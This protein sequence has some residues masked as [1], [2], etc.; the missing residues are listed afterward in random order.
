[1]PIWDA[2]T[3]GSSFIRYST[4][5]APY[6]CFLIIKICLQSLVWLFPLYLHIKYF[7]LSESWSSSLNSDYFLLFHLFWSFTVSLLCLKLYVLSYP[8]NYWIQLGS[9]FSVFC[10]CFTSRFA[11]SLILVLDWYWDYF[12]YSELATAAICHEVKNS[13]KVLMEDRVA[14]P[15]LPTNKKL[16]IT[17]PEIL[18]FSLISDS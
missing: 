7:S 17:I 11:F 15:K 2:S 9:V 1:M 13:L 6:F 10:C 16:L 12:S 8:N 3:S 14:I 4:V 5:P 18:V